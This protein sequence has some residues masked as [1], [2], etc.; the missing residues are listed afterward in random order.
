M[1][2]FRIVSLLP[3]HSN[4]AKHGQSIDSLQLR[5]TTHIEGK[6]GDDEGTNASEGGDLGVAAL[7]KVKDRLKLVHDFDCFACFPEGPVA[8]RE[9]VAQ[10]VTT[11]R[12]FPPSVMKWCPG[13]F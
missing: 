12:F 6:L 2:W 5:K 4:A 9:A 3:Q 10:E 7:D 8:P 11:I 13:V 1:F